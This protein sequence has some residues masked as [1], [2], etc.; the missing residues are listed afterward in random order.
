M[1]VPEIMV[2]SSNNTALIIK[3][4][5]KVYSVFYENKKRDY[6][7]LVENCINA[8]LYYI[9][10][11]KLYDCSLEQYDPNAKFPDFILFFNDVLD[12][13]ASLLDDL[14][15]NF[16]N[17]YL[18]SLMFDLEC[19]EDILK[20]IDDR[21]EKI[22]I[23]K[24]LNIVES[25]T[26]SIEPEKI[27]PPEY[28][29]RFKTI[30][31]FDDKPVTFYEIVKSNTRLPFV[32]KV[33]DGGHERLFTDIYASR[34][35]D[36]NRLDCKYD[37]SFLQE[38]WRHFNLDGEFDMSFVKKR[39]DHCV[40]TGEMAPTIYR[41]CLDCVVENYRKTKLGE[42]LPNFILNKI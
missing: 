20:F 42:T 21:V 26:L 6:E 34:D 39:I 17:I 33:K 2:L 7:W 27:E 4:L 35:W 1:L 31:D 38:L 9:Y 22:T 37:F 11:Q 24:S 40:E 15:Y 25:K 30:I 5:E 13:D 18:A 10:N 8:R 23:C 16:M 3:K 19:E 29:F 12:E 14:F 28:D 41:Q 36:I 32:V